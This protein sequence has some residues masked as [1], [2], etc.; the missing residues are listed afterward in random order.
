MKTIPPLLL[1]DLK[2]DC[3]TI[4]FLWTIELGN[5]RLIR[6]TEHDLDITIPETGDSPTDKYAGTYK[7]VASVTFGDV[8][9]T[10]DLS[11]DNL[12]VTGAEPQAPYT[13]VP[14]VTV[15][16]IEAGLCDTAPVNVML[17]NWMAPSHG[18]FTVKTGTLGAITRDSDGKYVT[19]VRGL[20]QALSQA[21]IRL[22]S[23]TCNVV[24]FGDKRCK[25]DVAG[26]TIA[27]TVVAE[28]NRQLFSVDLAE[29][30]PPSGFSYEGGT[31]TFTSGAN[32]GFFREV[33]IDP[34]ANG[35]L[36]QFWDDFPE[37]MVPGD[38]FELSP[39]CDRQYLTCRDVYHNLVNSR[40]YGVFIP[41]L[42]AL[43]SGP[44][45]PLG[46]Q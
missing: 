31:L 5:G 8:V 46:M 33:K 43:T 12:E 9:S 37:D 32:A 13:A 26:A 3:T 41:G 30:S 18:Y 16:D 29:G 42:L 10:S 23:A 20:T 2:A 11:V 45:T 36:I 24:K 39:G 44:T 25:F 14:D 21:I 15:D 17:C 38:A 7:A 35:G 22:F 6:G 1:A 34:N 27:G 19:E 28:T 4:A 40:M